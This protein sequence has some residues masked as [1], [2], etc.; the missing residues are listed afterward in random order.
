MK[1]VQPCRSPPRASAP[2]WQSGPGSQPLAPSGAF[3][4]PASG[5]SVCTPALRSRNARGTI[6]FSQ[7][8]VR[9]CSPP[10]AVPPSQ[11][12]WATSGQKWARWPPSPSAWSTSW[13]RSQR[14]GVTEPTRRGDSAADDRDAETLAAGRSSSRG[15]RRIGR[16]AR[17]P[18]DDAHDRIALHFSLLEPPPASPACLQQQQQQRYTEFHSDTHPFTPREGF[19]LFFPDFALSLS[20]A[21]RATLRSASASDWALSYRRAGHAATHGRSAGAPHAPAPPQA[22]SC[23]KE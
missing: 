11:T 2:G 15:K 9:S 13:R 20:A 4:T 6:P 12:E 7:Y 1:R 19:G 5:P 16:H 22:A 21:P 23:R 14:F 18:R 3:Q 17:A 10:S 8:G